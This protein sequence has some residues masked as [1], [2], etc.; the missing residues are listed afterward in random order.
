MFI[1]FNNY[2]F[3][4]SFVKFD[5]YVNN[6]NIYVNETNELVKKGFLQEIVRKQD[7]I[8]TEKLFRGLYFK[9]FDMYKDIKNRAVVTLMKNKDLQKKH[10]VALDDK[11]RIVSNNIC[12]S[13]CTVVKIKTTLRKITTIVKF[14]QV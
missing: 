14:N 4:F 10:G 13:C 8:L 5:D 1:K 6:S 2:T 7:L 12:T 9:S 11:F 3:S